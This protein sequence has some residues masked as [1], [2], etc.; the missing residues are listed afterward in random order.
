VTV[1]L[2]LWLLTRFAVLATALALVGFVLFLW[3]LGDDNLDGGS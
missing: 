1:A 2:V 3:M